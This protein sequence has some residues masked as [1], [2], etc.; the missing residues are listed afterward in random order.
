MD[1]EQFLEIA[2]QV[3]KLKMFPYFEIAHAVISCLYIRDDLGPSGHTFSRKHPFACWISSMVNI[4]AS[5]ILANFLLG[6]PILSAFK[7]SNQVMLATIVWY[8]I[9][10]SP[11]DCIYKVTKFMP[12]K[13]I[14]ASMKEIVRCKKIHDGV[15]HASKIYPDGY[16]IMTIVGTAKGN[17]A[18]FIKVLER[19][20]RGVWTP[21]AMEMITPTFPTKASIVA[22]IIFIIDKKT[23]WI[24]IPHALIYFGV[25]IFFVYFKLSSMLLGIHDPFIPFENLFSF[26]FLGGVWDTLTRLLTNGKK[27]EEPKIEIPRREEMKK[28]E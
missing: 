22:S 24:S 17:G 11:F 8:L 16:L 13:V 28:K 25:V 27:G 4:F 10:Y 26:I 18:S 19:L 21:N 1:S 5:P 23:D 3:A 2:N 12:C 14:L 20:I 9:F 15:S 6:E 7:S